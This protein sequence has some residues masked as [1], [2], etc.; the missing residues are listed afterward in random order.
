MAQLNAAEIRRYSWRPEIILKKIRNKNPFDIGGRKVILQMPKN[1]EQ[2]LRKGTTA[3]LN[4]L[5]FA[6]GAGQV[7]ALADLTKTSEFGKKDEHPLPL[8]DRV[9]ASLHRQLSELKRTYGSATVPLTIRGKRYDVYDVRATPGNFKSNIHFVDVDDREIIWVSWYPGQNNRDVTF[10]DS[11]KG[12]ADTKI[13]THRETQTFINE[14][15]KLYPQ[16]LTEPTTLARKITD[17]RLKHLVLYGGNFGGALGRQNVTLVIRG[18]IKLTK[19]GDAC[20]IEG[21]LL[22]NNGDLLK[23]GNDPVFMVSYKTNQSDFDIKNASVIIAPQDSRVG[24]SFM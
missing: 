13:N 11:A 8:G 21:F 22:H 15:K 7:Y 19:R 3:E 5:R 1:G 17:A 18:D 24:V 14:I 12:R 10:W 9:L 20:I 4:A 2:V 16:G 23:G 6:G